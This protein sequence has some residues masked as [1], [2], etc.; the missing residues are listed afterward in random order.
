MSPLADIC[1]QS[2]RVHDN[3]K[4]VAP[5]PQFMS[6]KGWAKAQLAVE[7]FEEV[8]SLYK[9]WQLETVKPTDYE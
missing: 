5:T 1:A 4:M 2:V 8:I 6:M 9:L 7:A 3:V